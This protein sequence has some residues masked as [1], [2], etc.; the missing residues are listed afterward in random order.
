[1]SGGETA[2]E[3]LAG[4]HRRLRR[5]VLGIGDPAEPLP[6]AAESVGAEGEPGH[7]RLSAAELAALSRAPAAGGP[8]VVEDEDGRPWVERE[9]ACGSSSGAVLMAH[10]AGILESLGLFAAVVGVRLAGSRAELRCTAPGEPG[11]TDGCW[12]LIRACA[13]AAGRLSG[14]GREPSR[15]RLEPPHDAAAVEP[16]PGWWEAEDP[17]AQPEGEPG[18]ELVNA[19]LLRDAFAARAFV[20]TVVALAEGGALRLDLGVEIEGELVSISLVGIDDQRRA[21]V[22]VFAALVG[23]LAPLFG[24]ESAEDLL[25][26]ALDGLGVG[27][28]G[29]N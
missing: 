28:D 11:L 2:A 19:W 20:A 25:P 7:R 27:V 1:M 16:P 29:P 17:G 18:G 6:V 13:A 23:D 24:G 26:D 22:L 14:Q 15:H 3:R 21:D 9:L 5:L 4:I 12:L 10:F 8:A